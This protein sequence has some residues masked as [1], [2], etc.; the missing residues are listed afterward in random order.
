MG[1]TEGPVCL[2]TKD[3]DL[4]KVQKGDIVVTYSYSAAFKVVIGL[5]SG[6]CTDYGGMLSHAAMVA[7]EY[8][9]QGR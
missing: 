2:V 4:Q 8:G 9:I 1:Q 5:C 7:R 3:G 6:I